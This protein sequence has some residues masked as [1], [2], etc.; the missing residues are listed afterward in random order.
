MTD[1]NANQKAQNKPK[2]KKLPGKV[3]LYY[4]SVQGKKES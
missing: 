4:L 3:Y 2:K 1:K